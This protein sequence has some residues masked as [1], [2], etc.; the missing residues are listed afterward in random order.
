M[1]CIIIHYIIKQ[2]LTF[3]IVKHVSFRK[4]SIYLFY[5]FHSLHINF[6]KT[7][8]MKFNSRNEH[9]NI[10]DRYCTKRESQIDNI[11]RHTVKSIFC[12]LADQIDV[13]I[14]K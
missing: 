12:T 8:C 9:F 4:Q 7:T 3:K 2:L 11:L 1:S 5:F 10:Q 13:F 14:I 6:T